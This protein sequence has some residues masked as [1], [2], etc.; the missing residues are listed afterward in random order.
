M[1]P[2]GSTRRVV[3]RSQA[4]TEPRRVARRI[5]RWSATVLLAIIVT[6]FPATSSE[7]IDDEAPPCACEVCCRC[8][9][10][11]SEP[12]TRGKYL[13]RAETL[14]H[15]VHLRLLGP[16]GSAHVTL[17]AILQ[18]GRRVTG[19][20]QIHTSRNGKPGRLG[21]FWFG[22]G[23]EA[24]PLV[25]GTFTTRLP[26]KAASGLIATFLDKRRKE[27]AYVELVGGKPGAPLPPGRFLISPVVRMDRSLSVLG[28]F[29]GDP[30]DTRLTMG[31]R[32]TRVLAETHGLLSVELPELSTGRQDL[33][34]TEGSY[35]VAMELSVCEVTLD[36]GRELLRRG[37][38]TSLTLEI[39]GLDGSFQ[40][41]EVRLENRDP[42][43]ATLAGGTAQAI[44]VS[45]EQVEGGSY[46]WTD[47]IHAHHKG[48][49]LFVAD[50]DVRPAALYEPSLWPGSMRPNLNV[51][52]SLPSASSPPPPPPPPSP[53]PVLR[54][55]A[56]LERDALRPHD[57]YI[58]RDKPRKLRIQVDNPGK[59]DA[60]GPIIVTVWIQHS[61]DFLGGE[62]ACSGSP[63][64]SS[65]EEWECEHAGSETSAAGDRGM[66]R[67]ACEIQPGLAPGA[68]TP[69]LT[70]MLVL[71]PL[72]PNTP[73]NSNVA[74]SVWIQLF[75]IQGVDE[76]QRFQVIEAIGN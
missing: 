26:R 22:L 15:V 20:I 41:F 33:E 66:D 75:A 40:P 27:V 47:S 55:H 32:E 21:S 65:A 30:S 68:T 38:K 63:C 44:T 70:E 13:L 61:Y 7:S 73:Q 71:D 62:I 28:D 10:E 25:S 8:C 50:F 58:R 72:D 59:V 54:L 3:A 17:P 69:V 64:F 4:P 52:R 48:Q 11:I 23:D 19:R 34:L 76:W 18:A 57:K 2:V 14:D 9:P 67:Y 31:G 12:R 24:W 56:D 42:K 35:R 51:H 46:R 1:N 37:D 74:H 36:A 43:I 53:A 39:S 5:G 6:T 60:P 29:N 16:E 45:P 49:A